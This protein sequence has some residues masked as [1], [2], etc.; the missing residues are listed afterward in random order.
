MQRA[1]G[2]SERHIKIKKRD[3]RGQEEK[4]VKRKEIKRRKEGKREMKVLFGYSFTRKCQQYKV[5]DA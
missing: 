2:Q 3:K 1:A 4:Q 5:L